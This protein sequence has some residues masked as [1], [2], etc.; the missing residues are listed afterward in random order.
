MELRSLLSRELER[1]KIEVAIAINSSE[2]QRKSVLNKE[3]F[4]QYYTELKALNDELKINTTDYLGTILRL[5]D[6]LNME[7]EHVDEE[8]WKQINAALRTALDAF[9]KFRDTEGQFMQKDIK[10]RI[11][12]IEKNLLHVEPLET[13][14]IDNLRKKLSDQLEESRIKDSID[15]NRFEQEVI[16]YLEKMD[17]SEEKVR[18]RSHCK[19]FIDTMSEAQS[20][21]KKL[22]FIAQELG[23]E[24]NT[25]GSKAN[26]AGMQKFVV[27]MKDEL[28][29]MKE[30]LMNVL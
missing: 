1:G 24:I 9:N 5:P 3:V 4:R 23:R 25:I 14:R 19:Y 29:R 13:V 28:E 12:A 17:I 15:K 16:Y 27:Q 11:E 7:E 21:G 18:L 20:N 26:H 10:E 22:G 2:P 30:L 8:E 6:A